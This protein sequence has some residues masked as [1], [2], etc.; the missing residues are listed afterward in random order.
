MYSRSLPSTLKGGILLFV[1]AA[2]ADLMHHLLPGPVSHSLEPLLGPEAMTAHVLLVVAM[3]LILA[4]V[5]QHGV[6]PRA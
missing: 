5:A 4:G 1:V 6:R 2:A 3:G